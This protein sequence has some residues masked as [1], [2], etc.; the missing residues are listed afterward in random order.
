MNSV[1]PDDELSTALQQRADYIPLEDLRQET[2]E[3]GRLFRTIVTELTNR[4]L[5]TIVGPRGCGKTHMMR[6][7]WLTCRDVEAKPF[8][9][10]CSFQRYFRLEPLLS[11]NA[12]ATQLFHSWVLARVLLS[13][14]E[15]CDAWSSGTADGSKTLERHGY[16]PESLLELAAKLER[17]QLLPPDLV[18]FSDSLNIDKTKSIIDEMCE[19]A[20]RR[21]TILLLDDAAMTLTP[22][23][24]TE[25]LDIVRSL[26]S[27]SIAP[28]V[29]VYPGTTEAS[30]RFHQGQDTVS[31][32]A[33]VSVED[34]EYDDL[35]RDIAYVRVRNLEQIPEDIQALLRF[36]A[37][38]IPRAYLTML[39]DFQRGGFRTAQQ[40]VN[41]II[42]DHLGGRLA[43][44][45]TLGKKIPKLEILVGS[46]EQLLHQIARELK[47]YNRALLARGERGI[48]YGFRTDDLVPLL[49]RTINL[50]VEAG[51]LYDDGEVKHGSP[52]RVYKKV[53]PHGALLL[54]TGVF[55]GKESSG[56]TKESLEAIRSKPTKHPMRKS[57][58]SI[59]G[60][61]FVSGLNLALPKCA[62][63]SERRLTDNQ[64]FCHSC[65]HQLVDASTFNEC[66]NTPITEVPGLTEWQRQQIAAH[67]PFFRTI[68]D[69]LAKQDPAAELLTVAGFG[70]R[71]TARV[72]D[73]L[74]SF[75]DDYLS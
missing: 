33:W 58:G 64:R 36:A 51:L 5:R 45:R 7:S 42:R 12:G 54:T 6:F 24:L 75:V 60:P 11:S 65:G 72:V 29:S 16:S 46:G 69:Y 32:S 15:S 62:N 22:D 56:S 73:V 30:P 31:I 4:A 25:F 34:P 61:E 53:F 35:M 71:R 23:Y 14:K 68:R 55:S 43:E 44:Y 41:R 39:E 57:V 59:M 50:L 1:L 48:A 70:K 49:T 13:A 2:A 8:A 18:E 38:G 20:G 26:K 28:K 47:E 27:S 66:L 40:G 67:L 9:V 17:N 19:A 10:F 63:C 74:N 37:F 21:F 3:S 52:E